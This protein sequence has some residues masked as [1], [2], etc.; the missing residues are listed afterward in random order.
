MSEVR[1]LY[2]EDEPGN[3]LLVRRILEAEGFDVEEAADGVTGL[4]MAAD[5]RQDL[6]LIL[7][8][9]NLPEI[10]GYELAKRFRNTPGLQDIPI[11]AVTANVMHGDRKRT[12]DAGCDGYIQKPIDVDQLPHQIKA[13]LK[14]DCV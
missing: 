4:E 10:D 9:I 11:L 1:I 5:M 8:D 6:D 14:K 13:A 7:L 12:L 3:R 2:I